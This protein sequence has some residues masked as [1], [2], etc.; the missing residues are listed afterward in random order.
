MGNESTLLSDSDARHLLRRAG[1]DISAT[2]VKSLT[3]KTRGQAADNL[4][5]FKPA[6]FKPKGKDSREVHDRWLNYM[7]STANQL[8]EKLVLF[9]HDHF[10]TSSSTVDDEVLMANQNQLLRRYCK[11]N[12]KDFVKAINKDAA[13]IEFL[14]TVRN[15]KNSPNENYARELMELFTLGVYDAGGTSNYEQQDIVQIARAFSGWRYYHEDDTGP[16][17]QS[18][19]NQGRHDFGTNKVVFTSVG[20]FGPGGDN[21]TTNGTGEV[22]IDTVI[23]IIFNHRD[24]DDKST[25]ARY[26]TQKLLEYF[27]HAS[28]DIAVVDAV[29]AASGFDTSWDVGALMRAILVHDF[30]F[31]SGAAAP[32]GSAAKSVKW[33]VPYVVG[34]LRQLKMRLT[35]TTYEVTVDEKKQK[36]RYYHVARVNSEGK[37]VSGT[38]IQDLLEDMGQVLLQ[39]PSVFGW[40]W[41]TAWVNSGALLGRY[42]FAR[43]VTSARTTGRIGFRPEKL[44]DLNLT[45]PGAIVDAVTGVFGITDQFT[46]AERDILIDYLTDDGTVTPNLNDYEY[47][48]TKLNGVFALLLQSPSY[49]LQ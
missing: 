45:D 23:D 31:E 35:Y 8:Q 7:I 19:L 4:L 27:A 42:T 38:P 40:D 21:L 9:W 6:K 20:G 1:F 15:S 5:G 12:F 36:R 49:Q 17:G 24:S 46:S 26:I 16:F 22:E 32:F 28:P 34:A 43:D 18:Y 2:K 39:P 13:M 29:I 25:V 47:R 11:G 14:D 3:G 41:E 44:I 48:N 33:P 30:F 37:L 10:A